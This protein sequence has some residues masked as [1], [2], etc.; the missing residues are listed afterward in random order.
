MSAQPD[1]ERRVYA[2]LG[3]PFDAVDEAEA[4]RRVC[5]AAA[6]RRR[7]FLSTPN[8]NFAIGCL[9][10]AAFRQSVL[11]SDLSVADGW[12]VIWAAGWTDGRVRQRVAGSSLFE[13]L[14]AMRNDPPLKVFFL[15]GPPG[16]AEAAVARL[17]A[18]IGGVRGV[19]FDEGGFGDVEAM[20]TPELRA[21][22]N[23]SGAD[24]LVVA[25]GAKKG[26]AWILRN[27]SQLQVPVI[28]YLGAVVNF[29][30]GTVTRAPKWVQRV[31]GEWFWRI[32]QERSLFSRY[33]N[34]GRRL[35]GIVLSDLLP[36]S[37]WLKR[38][39]PTATALANARL[40]I[41][42]ADEGPTLALEGAWCESNAKPLREAL[43]ELVAE[44]RPVR[45]DLGRATY[46]DSAV[47]GLLMLLHG[48]HTRHGLPGTV[49]R[50]SP[51]ARFILAR[52]QAAY[53]L[54]TP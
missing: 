14:R 32:L 33:W 12:P 52:S 3:L 54:R 19:G 37:R 10:D 45:V 6:Q 44:G 9:D 11:E 48:W 38:R 25:V 1:F 30:A 4:A 15:G 13:R 34:D 51:E 28:S 7:C 23:A 46:I 35:L 41:L 36:L 5:E 16:A 24:F 2:V 47:L 42:R 29:V 21:K 49:A 43:R 50:A 8:L 20:S 17:N 22:I 40:E 27:Q 39:A 31:N 18:G 26:Q 53:L